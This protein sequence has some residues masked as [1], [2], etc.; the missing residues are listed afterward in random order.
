MT[1]GKQ[2]P[3]LLS[4]T[5]GS[6]WPHFYNVDSNYDDYSSLRLN[7]NTQVAAWLNQAYHAQMIQIGFPSFLAYQASLGR[8]GPQVSLQTPPLPKLFISQTKSDHQVFGSPSA[9]SAAPAPAQPAPA[10]PQGI[11]LTLNLPAGGQI[12]RVTVIQV[13]G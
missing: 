9:P 4:M 5:L 2:A 11:N 8:L 3:P 12:P 10:V 13:I 7:L 6:K 1:L